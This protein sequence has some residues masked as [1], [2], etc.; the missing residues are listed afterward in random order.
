MYDRVMS[1][2][3]QV[4]CA[5]VSIVCVG[6]LAIGFFLVTGYVPPPKANA[7][8]EEIADFYRDNADRLRAGL[9]ITFVAWAGWGALTA[10]I[11]VQMT[12][13]EGKRPV[14]AVLQLASGIAGWACLLIPTMLLAAA[15]FRPGRSP[16]LT[17][18]LHDLGWITAFMAI[19]PFIVQAVAIGAAT[20]QDTSDTPVYPR[21]LGYLSFWVA[22]LFAPGGLL[23]FF[24]TGP[25][26]YHGLL[27]FWVPFVVFGAWILILSWAAR[28]AAVGESIRHV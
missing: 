21:W 27:V 9:L 13:I 14:L 8:A 5:W 4:A 10:A 15:T 20:L 6:L 23:I 19:T 24:K 16:E 12:R 11:A 26:A 7:S 18:T 17:Q 3:N 25:F 28:R 2:K 22:L 1:A